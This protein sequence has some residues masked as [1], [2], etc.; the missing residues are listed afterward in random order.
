VGSG[1]RVEPVRGPINK[2]GWGHRR[3]QTALTRCRGGI[4]LACNGVCRD[5]R[6]KVV[7]FLLGNG[8][9]VLLTGRTSWMDAIGIELCKCNCVLHSA[10]LN[11]PF[12][13]FLP[14]FFIQPIHI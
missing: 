13:P 6:G 10:H 14:L 3:V 9:V 7:L 1:D 12:P 2:G 8:I 5:G 4:G 11:P